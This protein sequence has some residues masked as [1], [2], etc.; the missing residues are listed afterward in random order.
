ME[1]N[2]E[3][4]KAVE[5]SEGPLLVIA[6][7][8][9]G[10]TRVLTSRI[11]RL[12]ES[13]VP[14]SSILAITFTNKAAREMRERV[15]D[16]LG[17]TKEV[18]LVLTF[19][20]LGVRILK[21]YGNAIGVPPTFSIY[22]R[23][24]SLR[25]IKAAM[26][27]TDISSDS[28]KPAR[29]L[30]AISSKKGEGLSADEYRDTVQSAI[31]EVVAT[32]WEKY[33][34]LLREE[35]ALDFD[36]LIARPLKLL[37]ENEKV[38]DVYRN[39]FSHIHIDEYQDTNK[40]QYDIARLILNPKKNNIC[41]VGDSD[42]TIYTWR[43]AN[44]SN[45]L[46]FERD[47]ENCTTVLLEENYRSTQTILS[48][49]N[50][51]IGHNTLRKEKNLRTKKG[52]GEKITLVPALNESDEAQS[53]VQV[54][55]E[56]LDAG[57]SAGEIAVLYRT[58]FQS[59]IL[60]QAFLTSGIPYQVIG[61]RFFDRKEVKDVLSYI[62][63]A[64]N[65]QGWADI[66]RCISTPKRGIGK[67]TL[68]CIRENRM[69]ELSDRRRKKVD[70]FYTLLDRIREYGEK[71]PPS[72]VISFVLK[73]SGLEKELSKDK[74]GR[75]RL[76]N[77]QELATFALAYDEMEAPLG[78]EKMLEDAA[79]SSDQDE[80]REE[81]AAVRLMTVHASK[82]LEFDVVI[83]AGLEEGLFP[84]DRDHETLEEQEEERRL[85]YV[86]LTRARKRVFLT[87]AQMRTIFGNR[88]Y[89]IPSQFI[90]DINDELIEGSEENEWSR[91]DGKVEFLNLDE[92]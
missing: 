90:D 31:G 28:W 54:A 88:T 50:D 39:R 13:G 47:F 63:A 36:D 18:P 70:E 67:K 89:N 65:P 74:E 21:E 32:V 71:N 61:T 79:L 56:Q 9:A 6:G 62:R 40:V 77:A 34:S 29:I 82:G 7:A 1:L 3:Q 26:E 87:Y 37:K 75:D 38:R 5:H 25:R 64:R 23:S 42:Q 11:Y 15:R 91:G 35:N 46:N 41:V 69:N 45:I 14:A 33:D 30:G 81:E 2:P 19:H 24:D 86:A 8:G 17:V 4:Q 16:L 20:G 48:A 53:I 10:K 51:V 83:I 73:E 85:F 78:L 55:Q 57:V 22:D 80:L 43:G 49:A 60:E 68:E 92:L 84:Q 52:E 27:A 44:M 58:N 72:K 59:R 12:I 66:E 76:E